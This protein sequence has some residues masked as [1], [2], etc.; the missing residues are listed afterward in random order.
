MRTRFEIVLADDR[1]AAWLR[2]A[3]EEALEEISRVDAALSPFRRDSVLW[4]LHAGRGPVRVDGALFALM[5]RAG[6]LTEALDG[7]FDLTV[8]ALSER[9]RRGE[10]VE[11]GA[12][13]RVGFARQVR[14]DSVASTVT[15][16]PGAR[17]DPGAIGKGHALERAAEV[18]REAGV[19]RALLHGGT[20]SVAALGRWAVAV[21]HPLEPE[22]LARL[23]LCDAALGVSALHGRTFVRDGVPVAHVLDPRTG[24]PV[25]HTLLAAAVTSSPTDADALSTA[26]LV[27][28]EPALATLPARFPGS[29]L[30]LAIPHGPGL[31]L[32]TAGAAFRDAR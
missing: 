14:L 6:R 32:A 22:R 18:L 11:K 20:S 23:E 10:A 30:L 4:Q 19:K 15:L 24:E 12:L 31:R 5:A 8:G 16:A 27:L 21:Q 1:D 26:L 3:G 9:L 28:G 25:T 7:A 2:A 29:S 17:L 13:G